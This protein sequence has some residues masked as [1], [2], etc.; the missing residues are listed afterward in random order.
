MLNTMKRH[1]DI[2][3][4]Q[5]SIDGFF[6]NAGKYPGKKVTKEVLSPIWNEVFSKYGMNIFDLL[7]AQDSVALVK[8]YSN[9]Y[10][11][12]ISDGACAGRRLKSF[13][14][15]LKYTIRNKNRLKLAYSCFL[16][17]SGGCDISNTPSMNEIIETVYGKFSISSKI[18]IGRPYGWVYDG[19]F[20]HSE[21]IDH[22]YFANFILS[23]LNTFNCRSIGYLGDGS[24]ILSSV[25]NSNARN[26]NKRVYI[27]LAQYL[28]RQY[29]VNDV[30][31]ADQFIYA[32]TFDRSQ[33][34]NI[35]LLVNQDS[36]PEIPGE[37]LDEYFQL[38]DE[39]KIKYVLSYNHENYKDGHSDYRSLLIKHGMS[40]VF[41][42]CSTLRKNYVIELFCR[43]QI[44]SI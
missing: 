20:L 41:R 25:V 43:K 16:S 34:D 36:F 37:I 6:N 18:N 11:N 14:Y 21:L 40:S 9:Y 3:I 39:G 2:S 23:I 32:E 17:D 24:G 35:D 38:I 12:G 1:K 29:I 13:F 42:T 44:G 19:I 31:K 33:I 27:D 30:S 5:E 28:I 26:L 10:V 8:A 22:I 15:R 7:E 4:N